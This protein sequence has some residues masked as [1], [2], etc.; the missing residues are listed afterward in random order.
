MEL[1]FINSL[2]SLK[3]KVCVVSGASR[4]IGYGIAQ[5]FYEA[6]AY[7]HGLGRTSEDVVNVKWNYHCCDVTNKEKIQKIYKNIYEKEKGIHVLVNA[8]GITKPNSYSLEDF[9]QTIEINLI[10]IYNS[11]NE[12]FPLMRDTGG[13]SIINITSIGA[14]YGFPNNPS[15]GA[16][17]GGLQTLSKSLAIDF[18]NEKI[19]VNNLVPGYIKTDMTIKSFENEVMNNIRREKTI[20]KRWGEIKDL[21]GAA[22]FLASDAS[23]YITGTDLIVDGG[24]TAKGL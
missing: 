12:I 5:A 24:W 16:S 14:S 23:S 18:S 17:K 20:L 3:D 22:I 8:A 4:G 21:F 19:R 7:V 1:N 11:C 6:G 10:A 9:R 2:F 15:Y 13:G